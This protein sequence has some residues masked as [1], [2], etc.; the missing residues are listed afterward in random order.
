[1]GVS[2]T[3]SGFEDRDI[4]YCP[5]RSPRMSRSI[6]IVTRLMASSDSRP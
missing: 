2:Q 3:G 5:I 4:A 6:R 1:M